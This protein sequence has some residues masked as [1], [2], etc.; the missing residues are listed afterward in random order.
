MTL[1]VRQ[2]HMAA[3][4]QA[5]KAHR[6]LGVLGEGP[7]NVVSALTKA[8]VVV[9]F[10]PLGN[11]AGA[12]IPAPAAG[13]APPGVVVN[14]N[15]P[16]TRQRYTA[17]H[18]LCH[19]LRD[20]EAHFDTFPDGDFSRQPIVTSDRERIAEAFASWFLMPPQLIDHM[21]RLIG[22]NGPLSGHVV[23]DL[24]QRLGT[25]YA[26]TLM[27]LYTLGRLS[28]GEV[29]TFRKLRPSDIKQSLGGTKEHIH[30]N[31]VWVVNLDY[32]Q[33]TLTM[34]EGDQL[35][36][37]LP[38]SPSSGY[39]WIGH[40]PEATTTSLEIRSPDLVGS[41]AHRRFAITLDGPGLC[42]IHLQEAQH[43]DPDQHN[44]RFSLEVLV[45]KRV[46]VDE[47]VLVK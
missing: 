1:S 15:H 26:A 21:L 8:G 25:S 16:W 9:M 41:D 40:M 36:I 45:T 22:H 43:W 38:E 24:S 47:A 6:D 29:T 37:V 14:S 18:E 34:R 2:V 35:Q 32:H 23:F 5:L 20:R 46:G 28:Q 30:W 11:L 10:Q 27:H 44:R 42:N 39:E 17:A 19:H 33:A 31:D 12:Y 3:Y 13:T 7:V 4:R